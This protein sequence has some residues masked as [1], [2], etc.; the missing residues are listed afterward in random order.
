MA[1]QI[2]AV[3]TSGVPGSSDLATEFRNLKKRV[4]NLER[5]GRSSMADHGGNFIVGEDPSTRVGLGRPHLLHSVVATSDLI[6]PSVTTVSATFQSLW[7]I[8]G[9][10]QQPGLTVFMSAFIPLGTFGEFQIVN[11]DDPTI[12]LS[13]VYTFGATS[14]PAAADDFRFI[15]LDCNMDPADTLYNTFRYDLQGRR[16][17]GGGTIRVRVLFAAG[18]ETV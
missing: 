14:D 2:D 17:S 16:T 5:I 3:S 8:V 9:E 13:D 10:V 12:V 4:D 18:R 7:S 6:M 1:R 11:G 15:K